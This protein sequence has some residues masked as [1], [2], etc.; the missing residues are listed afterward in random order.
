MGLKNLYK[1]KSPGPDGFNGK[2]YQIFKEEMTIILCTL[3]RKT[4][5]EGLCLNSHFE[6]SI[7]PSPTPK[8][9]KKKKKVTDNSPHKPTAK[10]F[11]KI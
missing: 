5:Q 2:F 3:F 10:I 9:A 4:E 7:I 1:K 6:S 11:N 8:D